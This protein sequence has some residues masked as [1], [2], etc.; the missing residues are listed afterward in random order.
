[1][2]KKIRSLSTLIKIILFVVASLVWILIATTLS[3]K[4]QTNYLMSTIVIAIIGNIF[5]PMKKKE[6]NQ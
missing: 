2:I 6:N 4:L 3:L 5:F 1:M